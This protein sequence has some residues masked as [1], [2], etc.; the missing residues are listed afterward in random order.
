V[1]LESSGSRISLVITLRSITEISPAFSES[2][3]HY[4]SERSNS[5][6]YSK[7][8]T[9]VPRVGG[10]RQVYGGLRSDACRWWRTSLCLCQIPIGLP[11]DIQ[12][13]IS[14]KTIRHLRD[15]NA[16]TQEALDKIIQKKEQDKAQADTDN[17]PGYIVYCSI[18]QPIPDKTS[19]KAHDASPAMCRVLKHH[20]ASRPH[21]SAQR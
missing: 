21:L 17:P 10:D 4:I 11:P 9:D 15:V 5:P 2:L 16:R 20:K 18:V 13:M 7:F 12:G 14:L 3:P 1:F 19:F 6:S 8:V